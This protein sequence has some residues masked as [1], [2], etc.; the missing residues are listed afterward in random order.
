MCHQ[1]CSHTSVPSSP[2]DS[3]PTRFVICH[4]YVPFLIIG[5][6]SRVKLTFSQALFHCEELRLLSLSDNELQSIPSAISSLN[7]LEELNISKNHILQIPETI[8]QCKCL[9][10][11]EASINPLGPKL[12]D[13]LTQL[14]NLQELYLNDSFL[15]YLPANFGK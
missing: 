7:K 8:K 11:V 12:P 15:E 14:I 2:F 9:I 4:V 1:A 3:I 6:F 13:S 5:L 10:R